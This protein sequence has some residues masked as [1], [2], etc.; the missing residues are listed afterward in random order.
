[1]KNYPVTRIVIFFISGIL[2]QHFIDINIYSF[3]TAFIFVLVLIFTINKYSLVY[4]RIISTVLIC[5]LFM[6]AGNITADLSFGGRQ[7]YADK[8]EKENNFTIY[9]SAEFVYLINKDGLRIDIQV[10]SAVVNKI[11]LHR[12]VNIICNVKDKE[13][14]TIDSLYSVLSPGNKISACGTFI[15]GSTGRNPGE[16]DYNNYLRLYG[17][18]GVLNVY[19]VSDFRIINYKADLFSDFI[20]KFRRSVAEKLS[21]Y[22]DDQAAALMNG[23]LLA[24]RSEINDQTKTEFVNA[25]VVH[26]LA[27]SGLNVEYVVLLCIILLG[28]FNIIPK[29]LLTILA[30]ILFLLIT[31]MSA[32]VFRAVLMTTSVIIAFITG[33]STNMINSMAIS[34]LLLL[35]FFPF[36]I[37][38][39]G[40]QLTYTAVFSMAVF[41]PLFQQH[42]KNIKSKIIKALSQL[43][44]LTLSAQIGTIPFTLYFFGKLSLTSLAAN[45]IVIPY[46]GFIVGVGLASLVFAYIFPL[47]A[48]FY[49]AINSLLIQL[50]YFIVHISG[51]EGY[52]F[53]RIRNFTLFDSFI[54]YLFL[55]SFLYFNKKFVSVLSKTVLIIILSADFYI[56]SLADKKD[57]IRKNELTVLM[58]DVGQGD[59]F[60]IKFPDGETALIDA[61][62]ASMKYD[63]GEKVIL[64]L[65]N[66]LDI[67]SIDYGFVSHIDTDHYGGFVSLIQSG[68]IKAIY[69]PDLDTNLS[70]DI[71]FESFVKANKLHVN[72]CKRE[73]LKVGNARIM[74]LNSNFAG[75]NK[76]GSNNDRSMF[77]K[78]VY[79]N[80]SFLFT[81]DL[82]KK[83]EDY[84]SMVYNDY[85][86]STVLKV[87]HHGSK[88]G[89][90]L[91]MLKF[92]SPKISLISAGLKN[93]YK[94]PSSEVLAKL[95]YVKSEIM[96]TDKQGAVLLRT[97]G[98]SVN[99]VKW[100]DYY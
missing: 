56:I 41:Y 69:K 98:V 87:S 96:H 25:G 83:A 33:R 72:H 7:F 85:L 55:I 14:K 13:H 2:L 57:L 15:K 93:K 99:P 78:I 23:L 75:L 44:A 100:R 38:D 64:P 29:S 92:I 86:K 51:G 3:P 53:I 39:P 8:I 47:A 71:K 65:L 68:L 61:G 45:L 54:F 37:Y 82:S 48:L 88:Y 59:S 63:Y 22:H 11:T 31:G 6:L 97:D 74:I 62:N 43:A 95:H 80:T 30:I 58:I 73:I 77:M 36:Y 28:R 24:D 34:A 67:D 84:Y 50:L 91:S 76:G 35:T 49:G 66:Y 60:L 90:S 27:V 20:F 70:R 17:T 1:M 5:F 79:G 42:I 89:S 4:G 19:A 9:G 32:S 10:D 52:S 16:F 18:T 94:H 46:I 81:G 21:I 12:N 40:F 26:V